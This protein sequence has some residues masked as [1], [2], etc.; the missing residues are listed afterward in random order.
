MNEY[1]PTSRILCS[2]RLITCRLAQTHTEGG[3]APPWVTRMETRQPRP[4]LFARYVQ[5]CLHLSWLLHGCH[6][7][8]RQCAQ[9]DKLLARRASCLSWQPC[10]A[11]NASTY[12]V[13]TQWMCSRT[14]LIVWTH[15]H[16]NILKHSFVLPKC[17]VDCVGFCEQM[18]AQRRAA[19]ELASSSPATPGP[20]VRRPHK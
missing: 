6:Q 12:E 14:H 15:E 13:R 8:S 9:A 7:L 5:C 18:I 11:P 2:G 19:R 20:S 10:L 17:C 3:C 1:S 4:P 16:C